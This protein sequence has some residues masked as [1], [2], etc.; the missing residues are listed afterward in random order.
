MKQG[1]F[2]YTPPQAWGGGRAI[3]STDRTVI[4]AWTANI[5]GLQTE[6]FNTQTY[7]CLE[8]LEWAKSLHNDYNYAF[9]CDYKQLV[10]KIF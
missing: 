6:S 5:A 2:E 4:Q 1:G 10:M 7:D 3:E 9:V 8:L